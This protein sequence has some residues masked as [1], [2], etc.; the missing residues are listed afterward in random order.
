MNSQRNTSKGGK[1]EKLSVSAML[2]SMDQEPDKAK[3][4]HASEEELR[5]Q[6]TLRPLTAKLLDTSLTNKILK[7]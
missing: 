2:A 3:K 5:K 7:N 1:K 6:R 4:D